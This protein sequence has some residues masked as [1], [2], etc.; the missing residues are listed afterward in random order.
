M[1]TKTNMDTEIEVGNETE[2]PKSSIYARMK[3]KA[4]RAFGAVAG[5][6]ALIMA[7]TATV[8]PA[9]AEINATTFEPITNLI[10]AVIPLFDSIL[11][12]IIAVFPLV[13]A[14]AFLAGL[15]LLINKIFDKSLNFGG[16][17]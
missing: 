13:I 5:V 15:A 11:D 17:K 8:R 16:K 1:D 6:A 10:D 3:A 4:S 12:L 7:Q 14:M 9:S 2:T